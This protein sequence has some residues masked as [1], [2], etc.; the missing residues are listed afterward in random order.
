MIKTN[1][2]IYSLTNHYTERKSKGRVRK[3]KTSLVCN[4]IKLSGCIIRFAQN[5]RSILSTHLKPK[6][7]FDFP[8]VLT[9]PFLVKWLPL[10][11]QSTTS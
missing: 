6:I 11:I 3:M 1:A 7:S 9:Q 2:Y 10:K 4:K 5:V 8:L